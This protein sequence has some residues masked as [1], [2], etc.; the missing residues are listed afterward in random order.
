MITT[1]RIVPLLFCA[2][3]VSV[4]M[5]QEKSPCEL[6]MPASMSA[7]AD[8]PLQATCPCRVSAFEGAVYNR[9]GVE[10]LKS[11]KMEGFPQGLL[12]VEDLADGT[13]LWK[14]KYTA[15]SNGDAEELE[16]MG[17]F[18]VLK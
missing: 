12:A 16:R 6:V 7:K 13:Y 5:A 18:T 2:F 4:S 14:V 17:Y 11:K 9:W 10:L 3:Y 1:A 15:I 8:L